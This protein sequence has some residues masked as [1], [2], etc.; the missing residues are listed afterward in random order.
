MII[1]QQPSGLRFKLDQNN[2]TAKIIESSE[3]INDVFIPRS[4]KYNSQEYLITEIEDGSF[5]NNYKIYSIIFSQDSEIRSIGQIFNSAIKKLTLPPKIEEFKD[6]WCKYTNS[7]VTVNLVGSNKNFKYL[8]DDHNIIVGKT[9]H[10]SDDYDIIIFANRNIKHFKVPSS[11]TRIGPYSFDRSSLKFLEFEENSKL[12]IIDQMAFNY[13]NLEYIKI[14]SSLKVLNEDWLG[15]INHGIQ[16]EISPGNSN[17]KLN[18]NK[19]ILFGKSDPNNDYFD[20]IIRS[21]KSMQ[22]IVIPSYIKRI[23]SYAF[24]CN[25]L[26]SVEFEAG[27]KLTYIGKYAFYRAEIRNVTIPPTVKYLLSE[28]WII[29]K[30]L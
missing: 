22:N 12:T 23:N 6:W 7:L 29:I 8:D 25:N 10:N 13:S 16:I 18:E 15:N 20:V 4:I 19:T 14:P 3:V 9:N 2:F 1:F 17:F 26:K 30:T 24:V 11:I 21:L 27:S 5:S 28:C